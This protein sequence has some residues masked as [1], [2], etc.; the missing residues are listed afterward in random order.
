MLRLQAV[1]I[2]FCHP[3][4]FQ[5][6]Y[7]RCTTKDALLKILKMLRTIGNFGNES[8]KNDE[9]KLGRHFLARR[10]NE[11]NGVTVCGTLDKLLILKALNTRCLRLQSCFNFDQPYEFP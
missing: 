11:V 6:H 8:M 10:Y 4:K 9:K 7:S 3:T 2:S 1:L 5:M